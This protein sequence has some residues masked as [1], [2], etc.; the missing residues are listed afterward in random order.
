MPGKCTQVLS[1][2]G[3]VCQPEP[4]AAPE[5]PAAV[6]E[7]IPETVSESAPVPESFLPSAHYIR[8]ASLGVVIFV[9]IPFLTLIPVMSV[10]D[11][12]VLP[13]PSALLTPLKF[14]AL[15]A[16]LKFPVLPVPLKLPTQSAPVKPNDLLAP[17]WPMARTSDL[18]EPTW[19][20]PLAPFSARTPDLPKPP[21]LNPPVPPWFL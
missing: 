5:Q 10:T 1:D 17:S 7:A 18:L 13:K 4:T 3:P 19:S 6:P 14:S 12:P 2:Q 8:H 15:L 20:V 16:P 9:E 21:W 11:L